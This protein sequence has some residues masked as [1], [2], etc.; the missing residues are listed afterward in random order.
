MAEGYEYTV[1]APD[2]ESLDSEVEV[3]ETP[4]VLDTGL[5]RTMEESTSENEEER[6]SDF[7]PSSP[8]LSCVITPL[9]RPVTPPTQ[10]AHSSKRMLTPERSPQG[11]KKKSKPIMITSAIRNAFEL[12]KERKDLGQEPKF[13]LLK[14]FLKGTAADKNAYFARENERAEN[15][16][17]LNN[18]EVQNLQMEKKQHERELACCRQQKRRQLLKETEIKAK[19][20]SPGGTKRKVSSAEILVDKLL[21]NQAW[22]SLRWSS[23]ILQTPASRRSKEILLS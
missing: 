8:S 19:V 2:M 16:Q 9:S 23:K 20:H 21:L 18:V 13:G 7:T 4:Q 15:T 6:A 17:S 5:A 1:Q 3:Y 12:S 14:F 11:H 10:I 22:S